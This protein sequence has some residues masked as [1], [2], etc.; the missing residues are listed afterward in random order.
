MLP[1]HRTTP[2]P[3]Q[4]AASLQLH[5]GRLVLD[6]STVLGMPPAALPQALQTA[7]TAQLSGQQPPVNHLTALDRVA[8]AVNGQLQTLLQPRL[9]RAGPSGGRS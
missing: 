3:A 7:V 2:S 1:R 8:G 5:V 6:S 9:L 4:A